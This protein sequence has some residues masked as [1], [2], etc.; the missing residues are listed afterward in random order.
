MPGVTISAAYGCGGA[1]VAPAVAEQLG[2]PLLDRAISSAVASQLH[3]TLQEA[4]GA[5]LKRSLWG[6]VL[7]RSRP[8][9]RRRA[10]RRYRRRPAG[11]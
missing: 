5:E 9:G 4:E 2:M 8:A 10:R 3:V 6:A 11:R 1:V 7:L